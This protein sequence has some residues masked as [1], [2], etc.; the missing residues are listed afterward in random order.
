MKYLNLSAAGFLA[1]FV[2]LL[3]FGQ[4]PSAVVQVDGTVRYTAGDSLTVP[5]DLGR[6]LDNYRSVQDFGAVGDGVTDDTQ[7]IQRA[8]DAC[9]KRGVPLYLQAGRT[10]VVGSLHPK[11]GLFFDLNGS[12]LK[13]KDGINLPVFDAW[14]YPAG[15]QNATIRNGTIDGNM[16]NNHQ[17]NGKAG[18]FWFTTWKN[19]TIKDINFVNCYRELVNFYSVDKARVENCHARNCGMNIVDSVYTYLGGFTDC[20]DVRVQ[21]VSMTDS[22]GFGLHFNRCTSYFADGVRLV[23]LTHPASIAITVTE[24][25]GGL[26]RNVRTKITHNNSCEIN[27]AE[28]LTLSDLFVEQ[29][30]VCG[31]TFGDNGSKKVSRNV[32]IENAV[33]TGTTGSKSLSL[34]YL[35]GLTVRN[36]TFDKGV[37]TTWAMPTDSVFFENSRFLTNAENLNFA[38]QRFRYSNVSWPNIKA[39]RHSDAENVYSSPGL[40]TIAVGD[41]LAVPMNLLLNDIRPVAGVLSTVSYYQDNFSQVTL[42]QRPVLNINPIKLGTETRTDGNV[43]RPLVFSVHPT[44]GVVYLH[45]AGDKPLRVRWEIH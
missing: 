8:I 12:T 40:V 6:K 41:S 39:L 33:V 45:N 25:N 5:L 37:N 3:T 36:S 24:G 9:S 15:A 21:D 13:L 14:A 28:N 20:S 19:V 2:P 10:Y 43:A 22:F 32:I 26:I 31:F 27:A 1:A 4:T 44:A 38:Y 16:A 35:S 18:A 17:P 7:A 42:Q 30:G 29:P 34:N 11:T 23:N